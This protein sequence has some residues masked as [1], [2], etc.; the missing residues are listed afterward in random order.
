MDAAQVDPGLA[1]LLRGGG[2]SLEAEWISEEGSFFQ[3]LWRGYFR[4]AS[5]K[6][7]ANPGLQLNFMPRRYWRYMTELHGNDRIR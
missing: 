6:E 1:A 2:G 7:R 3:E 5:I 4:S